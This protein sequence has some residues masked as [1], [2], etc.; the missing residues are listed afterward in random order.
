MKRRK[1]TNQNIK[2]VFVIATVI[3]LIGLI[4]SLLIALFSPLL[5]KASIK[6]VISVWIDNGVF[7]TFATIILITAALILLIAVVNQIFPL[8]GFFFEK[9]FSYFS[10]WQLC[11]KNGYSC[12]FH[13]A[14]F[15]SFRG[16]QARSDIE[17]KMKEKTLHVHF[18][19]IPFPFLR[20]F[21]LVNDREYRM[22]RSVPGKMRGFGGFIRPSEHEMDEKNYV[23]YTIPEF[24]PKETEFHY[25][26]IAPSYANAYFIERKSMLTVTGECASGNIIVCKLK[27]LKQRINNKLFTPLK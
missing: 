14:P 23:A 5:F 2:K 11:Q 1:D 22:H 26:V 8:I 9:L 20:M 13:R 24:S 16:V 3:V 21:L 6:K 27:I 19:D 17:I 12:R 15:A 18:I 10:I 25:L 4:F 7:A